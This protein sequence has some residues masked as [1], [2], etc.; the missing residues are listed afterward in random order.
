[1][2]PLADWLGWPATRGVGC[3]TLSPVS[4]PTLLKSGVYLQ[5]VDTF[6]LIQLRKAPLGGLHLPVRRL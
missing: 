1:M 5:S 4:V 3:Q 2:G 6:E